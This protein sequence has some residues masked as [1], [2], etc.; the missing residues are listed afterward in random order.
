MV[1]KKSVDITMS[2]VYDAGVADV[3]QMREEVHA[4]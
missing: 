1:R 2:Q 4:W 3:Q